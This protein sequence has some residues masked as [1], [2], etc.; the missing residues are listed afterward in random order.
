MTGDYG[1]LLADGSIVLLPS[2]DQLKLHGQC[3]DLNEVDRAI[4]SSD[5]VENACSIIWSN[6]STNQQQLATLWIPSEKTS[7]SLQLESLTNRLFSE[8]S[9]KLPPSEIPSLLVSV[10]E[11]PM[12]EAHRRDDA[13]ILQKLGQLSPEDLEA[14]S[15]KL[16]TDGVDDPL[17][18][19]ESTIA[20]ALSAVTGADHQHIRKHISF[21]KLGLDS[22]SAISFSRRLQEA[23]C[24]RLPVST[25]LRY[26]SV[27]QLAAV[28]PGLTN[29]HN[30][31]QPLVEETTPIF[32]DSFIHA[33]KHEFD[34]TDVS[35][36]RIYPC[37][38]L[39]EA[40]L[41]A[42]SDVGSA[43]FNHLLLRVNTDVDALKKAWSQML[44]RHDILRTCFKSTNDKQFA[45]AQVVLNDAALPW[46]Q[47][48][49]PDDLDQH[50]EKRKSEFESQS[51]VNGN[52]PYSLTV[53]MGSAS[54]SAHLLLSIHHALYD[55]EGIAQLLQELQLFLAGQ[56]LP[57]PTQFHRF[58][59]YMVSAS[60]DASDQYWDRYLSGVSPNLISTP[61]HAKSSVDQSASHQTNID[62]KFPLGSFKQRC[63]EL[64]VTPLNVFHAAWARLLSL[65]ADSSDVCFGNVF[66]CRT[67]PIEGADQIVGPCFNTLPIRVKFSSHSTNAD[68]LKLSQKH[69]SDILPHQLSPLR[70]IQRRV[71]QGGSRLFDTLVILQTSNTELD[72]RYWELLRDEGNMG[73]PLICEV[74]P[75][76][77]SNTI[78]IRLHFQVSHLGREVAE[79]L[80]QDFV[81][82]IEHTTQYPSAQAS[83]K[84]LI[85]MIPLQ[86]F[87]TKK[88]SQVNSIQMSSTKSEPSHAWSYQEEALREL[89]CKFSGVDPETVTL[90]T[91][92]FQLGLDSINA[93]Q[94][95]GTLRRLG[96]KISTGDILEV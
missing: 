49:I 61:E 14:F 88:G 41:A 22:L 6:P 71:L 92:I 69:N 3:I 76:E 26:S 70:R 50:V 64:S 56:D 52:L 27:A 75:D 95:S 32:D 4:L 77:S 81:A 82:L 28:V 46:A 84:Q 65:H 10:N 11:I 60:S 91:T 23:G 47:I 54:Q 55:G 18:D 31:A 74:V 40:M 80:A 15:R 58:I 2:R 13:N 42:D 36:G 78:H 62:L 85:G 44:Q 72:P 9:T 57:A 51:P 48:E 19:I 16:D 45:F 1:R 34:T 53:F 35:V 66:S 39:Q 20:G 29:G 89:L 17:T 8:I 38:P 25:I 79:K 21:Y 59:D 86:I 43:Y 24:G 73:L 30:P 5:F 93:V 67:V 63:K 90:H 37:T 96:Y 12:T 83:D 87:E 7:D 94:I 33:V 68:I